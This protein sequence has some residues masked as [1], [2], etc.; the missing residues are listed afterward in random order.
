MKTRLRVYSLS[1]YCS[2]EKFM[3][4]WATQIHY[5]M[6]LVTYGYTLYTRR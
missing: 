4:E 6:H 1:T 3:A 5:T 2:S